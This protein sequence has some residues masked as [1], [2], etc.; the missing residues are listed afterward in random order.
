MGEISMTIST[1]TQPG[2]RAEVQAPYHEFMAPRAI[3]NDAQRMVVWCDD[4]ERGSI[5]PVRDLLRLRSDGCERLGSVV[6]RVHGEGRPSARRRASMVMAT[7]EGRLERA[8]PGGGDFGS[9]LA[10]GPD[11]GPISRRMSLPT[12]V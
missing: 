12:A 3:E 8:V 1:T 10:I 4:Q 7:T 2:K 11:H 5:P 6:C 9:R